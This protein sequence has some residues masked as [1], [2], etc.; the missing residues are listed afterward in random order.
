V[1]MGTQ[2]PTPPNEEN[3]GTILDPQLLIPKIPGHFGSD[4]DDHS[5]AVES[6]VVSPSPELPALED[7]DANEFYMDPLALSA[8]RYDF[9]ESYATGRGSPASDVADA[10]DGYDDDDEEDNVR[11]K[12][13]LGMVW[14]TQMYGSFEDEDEHGV[15]E[16]SSGRVSPT[17]SQ[18][19]SVIDVDDF[20]PR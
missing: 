13:I 3:Y 14:G 1:K 18:A 5:G 7:V 17:D 20:T 9:A 10:G 19:R 16:D 4:E 12:V 6:A 15:P 11:G 2:L 8:D